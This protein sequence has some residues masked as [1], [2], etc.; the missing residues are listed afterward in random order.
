MRKLTT[1]CAV[2]IMSIVLS[3]D[4]FAGGSGT[5]S[6]QG[7]MFGYFD[8]GTGYGYSELDTPF[9]PGN[10][11]LMKAVITGP[12]SWFGFV[13]DPNTGQFFT[14]TGSHG[15]SLSGSSGW[16][17]GTIYDSTG[18]VAGYIQA[19]YDPVTSLIIPTSS[20]WFI[21]DCSL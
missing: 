11:F 5:I 2:L 3:T 14:V 12:N 15:T 9:P 8:L 20:I 16:I 13:K 21:Y 1:S 4:C 6:N 10:P 19:A 18:Q 17:F 7:Q